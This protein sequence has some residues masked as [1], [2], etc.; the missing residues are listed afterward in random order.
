MVH[1]LYCVFGQSQG[2]CRLAKKNV[3]FIYTL[4]TPFFFL[5]S[6]LRDGVSHTLFWTYDFRVVRISEN[7]LTIQFVKSEFPSIIT[8]ASS[9]GPM[10]C[11]T[12]HSKTIYKKN[13]KKTKKT[14]KIQV[15][16]V[17]KL[18]VEKSIL[19]K[20]NHIVRLTR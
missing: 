3:L 8:S 6:T 15:K 14:D 10:L 1:L 13:I 12:L 20:L 5:F 9:I 2:G 11:E 7:F 17:Q 16:N 18:R 19:E 4:S